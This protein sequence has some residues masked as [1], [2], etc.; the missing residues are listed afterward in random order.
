MFY[1]KVQDTDR[2]RAV[3]VADVLCEEVEQRFDEL[4]K[5]KSTDVIA[6]L[7]K[8]VELAR[9][10]LQQA[11]AGLAEI[12]SSVGSDLSELR[13]LSE[14]MAGDS[15]L[16]RTLVEVKQ[17]LRQA[18]NACQANQQL[19]VMLQAAQKDPSHLVATPNR[20][21]ESQPALRRLK[22]G[23]IDT[24]LSTSRLLG[25]MS[26]E[27]P[28][29]QASL[30]AE[31]EIQGHLHRELEVAI[32]GLR[33]EQTLNESLIR[34]LTQKITD[35]QDR[36][37]RLAAIRANYSNQVAEVRQ[38]TESLTRAQHEL[39]SA[40]GGLAAGQ[41]GSLLTR[42]DGPQTGPYPAGPGRS[43]VAASGFAGGLLLGLGI[44]FLTAPTTL[45][46]SAIAH[47]A[48]PAPTPA[49]SPATTHVAAAV[50]QPVATPVATAPPATVPVAIPQPAVTMP[51]AAP[52][53]LKQPSAAASTTGTH[54]SSTLTLKD[55]L[56]R[57]SN[58]D[59]DWN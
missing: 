2:Q 36:L 47:T 23:L 35:L 15:N 1:L 45:A 14:S 42:I 33:A 20:L 46:T 50:A 19:L 30:V 22:E 27:H 56:A 26:A 21:L 44:L 18:E 3:H 13:M 54:T 59:N 11:T 25:T 28:Q 40:R 6:E 55:A 9:N 34:A 31:E 10:E 52:A 24:Q 53:L 37:Q 48:V 58:G 49:V 57:F 7:T 51:M 17:E 43:V 16:Q 39:T 4:R 38:Q 5:R 8:A 29:V 12:E 41:A 32:R